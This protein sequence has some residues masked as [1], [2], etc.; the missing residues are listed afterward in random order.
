MTIAA[1]FCCSDGIVLCADTQITIQGTL[2]YPE[3][4]IR[5]A[6]GLATKPTFAFCGDVD[7]QKQC[8]PHLVNA[9]AEAQKNTENPLIALQ[10]EALELHQT[11]WETFSDPN[12]KLIVHLLVSLLLNGK[13]RLFKILGPKVTPVD[14]QEFIGAG[15]Y[16]ARAL[17]GTYWT[18]GSAIHRT[19]IV[20]AFMLADVK[21][22][23][24]GCGM[25]SQIVCLFNDGSYTY[26]PDEWFHF[27]M[28]QI[29]SS[30]DEWK[31][32][33]R[34][35]A[36]DF[37]DAKAHSFEYN[38]SVIV[39]QLMETKGNQTAIFKALD[40]AAWETFMKEGSERMERIKQLR[41]AETEES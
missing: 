20:A 21:K 32:R 37:A 4:K 11:Y 5:M 35:L 7:F 16:L 8:I 19:A 2:K 9:L 12:D 24:D 27:D 14:S 23:V 34:E 3:S 30:Y 39:G 38:L 33:T 17:S 1:G 31:Q 40:D 6:P 29:E 41:A 15:C 25:E 36:I 22:Y 10:M 13:R 26:F 18:A 28:Q